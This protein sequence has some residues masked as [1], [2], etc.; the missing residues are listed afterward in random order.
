MG[1]DKT[2]EVF[3]DITKL[4]VSGVKLYKHGVGLSS[5]GQLWGV[6]DSLKE[7][8]LDLPPAMPELLDLDNDECAKLGRAAHRM[9]KEVAE[10][11]A[12]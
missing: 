11:F 5:F 1:I 6:I 8:I 12:E 7:L 2:L 10:A 3:E 4:A 9:L